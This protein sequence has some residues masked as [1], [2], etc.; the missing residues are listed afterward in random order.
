MRAREVTAR[1][2]AKALYM[3]AR[4]AG[5]AATVG[6]ELERFFET[7][8]THEQARDVL[9][10]PWIKPDDRRAIAV[11][12]AGKNAAGRL[13]QN[14]A[15][16]VAERGRIDHLPEIVAAYRALADEDLGQARATVRSAVPLADDDKQ[17]LGQRLEQVLGKRVIL[18]EQIDPTLLGGFVAQVGSYILDGSL[19]GQLARLRERLARG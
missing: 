7:V 1:R 12:L 6:E 10:R 3:S 2:Y 19:D 8:M 17:R 15:G 9:S 14:F 11:E 5:L 4:E 18:E 16:L 13:V